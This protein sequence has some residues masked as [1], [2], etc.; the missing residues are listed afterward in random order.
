MS[1]SV[2]AQPDWQPLVEYRRNGVAEN[3]VHGAVS[4]VSG[5]N[6]IYSFGG[7]VEC[8]GRSMVK[9]LMMKVFTREFDKGISSEQKAISVASHNGDTEHVRVARSLLRE[10]EWGLMQTPHDVPL[11]QFGRQVRRPRRWYHCCSGEHAAILHGCRLKGWSR[12]GYV[13]PHHPFFQAYL[14]YISKTLGSDWKG[15]VIA[16]DGCGLPTVSMTVT[17]LARLFAAM[18]TQKD[19][20]WIWS[21]MVAHPDLIGGF[22]R[23]D[24]TILKACGGR[25]IAKEGADGLLGMAI[26]HPDF[27]DGLGVVVKI[28]HGWNPQATWYIARFILGVLGFEF[29]NPYKLRRQKAFIVPEVIPPDLRPRMSS[30]VPWDSW[31]PDIDRWEFDPEEFQPAEGK[32]L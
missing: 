20:D 16:K 12:V 9:P 3:T 13:W 5:K 11:V 17:V 21:S 26:E 32:G 8:Y 31:D 10:S 7:N 29:R 25:V 28:A 18:V 4:W 23:L 24:S 2:R 15:G 1:E 22:N 30:I 14:D 19:D 6:L 27:P